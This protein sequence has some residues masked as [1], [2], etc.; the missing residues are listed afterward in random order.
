M[1]ATVDFNHKLV[2]RLAAKEASLVDRA[3]HFRASTETFSDNQDLLERGS[4]QS[5]TGEIFESNVAFGEQVIDPRTPTGFGDPFF[6]QM[7]VEQ[8]IE[9]DDIMSVHEK[10]EVRA[11]NNGTLQIDISAGWHFL[12]GVGSLSK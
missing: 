9:L 10:R 5:A 4:I 3:E 12:D 7:H 2:E 11:M 6:R 8:K 1:V